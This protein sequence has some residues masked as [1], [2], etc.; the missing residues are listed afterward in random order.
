MA[1]QFSPPIT[2]NVRANLS[3][4]MVQNLLVSTG[5][6]CAET[7]AEMLEKFSTAF[8]TGRSLRLGQPFWA[9]AVRQ[10]LV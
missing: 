9:E 6:V 2:A 7:G 1:P 10:K 4:N 5:I 8:Q 3:K